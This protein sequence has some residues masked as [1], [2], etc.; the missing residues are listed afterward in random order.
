MAAAVAAPT[1]VIATRTAWGHRE[2][3][4]WKENT[5]VSSLLSELWGFLSCSPSW[6]LRSSL[7]AHSAHSGVGLVESCWPSWK[8]RSGN[9]PTTSWALEPVPFPACLSLFASHCSPVAVLCTLS[10]FHSCI[11]RESRGACLF[12]ART[13]VSDI[14][15]NFY[16]LIN[17]SLYAGQQLVLFIRVPLSGQI[18]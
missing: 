2:L 18:T 7:L 5:R 12:S 9:V 6:L 8:E 11:R 14:V 15:Y 4:R 16:F 17:S 13:G 3:R 10:S 1:V